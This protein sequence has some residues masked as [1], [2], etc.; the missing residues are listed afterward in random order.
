LSASTVTSSPGAV[1]SGSRPLA[2]TRSVT[3]GNRVASLRTIESGNAVEVS[4]T[5]TTQFQV[6]GDLLELEIGKVRSPRSQHPEGDTKRV[7][8]ILSKAAF[9]SASNGDRLKVRYQHGVGNTWDFG[10]LDKTQ[11]D[12]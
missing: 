11:L 1:T 10:A 7:T 2:A 4:L 9:D 8:F 3:T 5:T 12:K 6:R